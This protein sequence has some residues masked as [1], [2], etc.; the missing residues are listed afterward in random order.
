MICKS[1]RAGRR[2]L[3]SQTLAVALSAVAASTT[4]TGIAAAADLGDDLLRGSLLPSFETQSYTDWSG[5]NVGV[6][7]GWSNQSSDFG[8]GSRDLIA[9]ILR[10]T[11]VENE[12][13]VSQWTT[14]GRSTANASSYGAFLGYSYAIEPRL[15]VGMDLTYTRFASSPSSAFSEQTN[16]S[17]QTN[18]GYLYD[19][20]LSTE[21]RLKLKDYATLRGRLGYA[22]G[23]FLPY[24]VLG[25]AA[26]RVDVQRMASV[27][28]TATDITP[29]GRPDLALDPNPTV[30][31]DNRSTFAYG[32]VAGLGI[33]AMIMP[34][35]FL[36]AEY[37]FVQFAP[38]DGIKANLQ[39]GRV[40]LG[41]KF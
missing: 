29:A 8:S 38:I 39:T 41:M 30:R 20:R 9:Y 34:N 17:Y 35:L 23:Q 32:L 6:Y 4:I 18:D 21:S 28:G 12:G 10:D 33:D 24:A 26:G 2:H 22:F 7:Y 11:A 16:G 40:G 27:Y 14:G 3:R 1:D 31:T 19:M 36:R 5:V 13:H 15:I 25:V 37:E